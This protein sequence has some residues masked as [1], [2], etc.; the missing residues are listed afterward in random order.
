RRYPARSTKTLVRLTG[1]RL[2]ITCPKSPRGWL[3]RRGR[4]GKD[5]RHLPAGR[6]LQQHLVHEEP[7]LLSLLPWRTDRKHDRHIDLRDPV[8]DQR[9]PQ[10]GERRL[11]PPCSAVQRLEASQRRLPAPDRSSPRDPEELR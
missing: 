2:A 5:A 7:R 6:C 3:L 4:D 9:D 10:V 8:G 11:K 1:R